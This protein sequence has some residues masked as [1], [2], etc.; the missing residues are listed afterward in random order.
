MYKILTHK[1]ELGLGKH[2]LKLTWGRGF[3]YQSLNI[4]LSTV[5]WAIILYL[6]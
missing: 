3:K 1:H 2:G 4:K 6:T 5:V